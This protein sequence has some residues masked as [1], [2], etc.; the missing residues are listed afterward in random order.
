MGSSALTQMVAHLSLIHWTQTQ[1]NILSLNV[2]MS[3]IQRNHRIVP[4]HVHTTCRVKWYEL[5]LLPCTHKVSFLFF[6]YLHPWVKLKGESIVIPTD[7]G[8][9]CLYLLYLDRASFYKTG[10]FLISTGAKP[11]PVS[12]TPAIICYSYSL[13]RVI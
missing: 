9:S 1:R 2:M 8:G 12:H 10:S 4:T 3:M 13:P 5:S 7:P 11:N 6:C